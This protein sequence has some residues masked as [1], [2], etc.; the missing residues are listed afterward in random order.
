MFFI[1][2]CTLGSETQ[3]TTAHKKRN[4]YSGLWAR[5]GCWIVKIIRNFNAIFSHPD[6]TNRIIVR[7]NAQK[8]KIFTNR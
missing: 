6:A 3:S 2:F 5:A 1:S 8:S 4:H 7:K